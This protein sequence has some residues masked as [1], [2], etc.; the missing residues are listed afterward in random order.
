MNNFI[1]AYIAS[2]FPLP[3][4]KISSL[5][6]LGISNLCSPKFPSMDG[7]YEGVPV[8]KTLRDGNYKG[9]REPKSLMDGKPLILAVPKSLIMFKYLLRV[10]KFNKSKY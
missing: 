5:V 1:S 2:R 4:I 6:Q 9:V 7:N 8:L 3:F 10:F